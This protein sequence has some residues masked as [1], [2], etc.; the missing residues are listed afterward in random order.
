MDVSQID[1]GESS[2]DLLFIITDWQFSEWPKSPFPLGGKRSEVFVLKPLMLIIIFDFRP[3][4]RRVPT[5][6]C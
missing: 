5:S 2:A 4:T 1:A 3:N 6:Y